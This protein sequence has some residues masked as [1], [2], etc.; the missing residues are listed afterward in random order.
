MP[1]AE[2]ELAVAGGALLASRVQRRLDGI[3]AGLQ[4]GV[5]REEGAGRGIVG[6]EL[7]RAVQRSR[8]IGLVL[9]REMRLGQQEERLRALRSCLER[10]DRRGPE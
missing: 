10:R 6:L 4:R 9:R 3:H 1:A 5:L 2:A 8:R 7:D